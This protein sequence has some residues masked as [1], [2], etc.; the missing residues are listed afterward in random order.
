MSSTSLSP[1]LPS[2]RGLTFSVLNVCIILALLRLTNL[3]YYLS[4]WLGFETEINSTGG[5]A[6]NFS[7]YIIPVVLIVFAISQ[8]RLWTTNWKQL[9][10]FFALAAIYLLSYFLSPMTIPA[11]TAYQLVFICAAVVMHI[12]SRKVA[13]DF[14]PRFRF[15]QRWFF[16][17]CILFVVFCVY[18]MVSQVPISYLFSEYNDSFVNSLD[19]FGVMKQRFGYLL[20]FLVSYCI[21]V[22][23][24]LRWKVPILA[25]LVFA[26]FGIR[27]YLLGLTGAF[28]IFSVK[29]PL[30]FAG[31][32]ALALFAM[33]FV[34]KGYFQNIVFD[35][36]FYSYYNAYHIVE[37]FPFGVGLG[38][39]PQFTETFM[40]NLLAR[41]YNVNAVLDY[42]PSAPESDIVHIFASLG[43]VL[44]GL[45]LLIQGRLVYYA[46]IFQKKVRPFEKCIL[47]YFC[48][49]TFFGI[50][51]D[52]IFS[53]NYW[54][55]F[56]ISSGIISSVLHRKSISSL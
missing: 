10:P 31:V 4:V 48:F 46:L 29:N 44:G 24:D 52:S 47:F 11:W 42:I 33:V 56:G 50:S 34:L 12:V 51:E 35:T 23:K 21:Y 17:A 14:T 8:S 26:G 40:T 41:I 39:Y 38:G 1:H 36:R 7:N 9:W 37:T 13:Q 18:Q 55:F 19:D 30:R 5:N 28:L 3:N 22:I 16:V 49:M 6:F 15:G 25:L 53:I 27:S 20:G 32:L 45:H 54:I 2:R 43:A